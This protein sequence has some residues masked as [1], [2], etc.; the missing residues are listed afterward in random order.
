MWH[1][2][3]NGFQYIIQSVFLD[4]FSHAEERLRTQP[5]QMKEEEDKMKRQVGAWRSLFLRLRRFVYVGCIL[6]LSTHAYVASVLKT[7]WKQSL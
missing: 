1:Q 6:D 7:V 2:S 4:K 5:K 3:Y